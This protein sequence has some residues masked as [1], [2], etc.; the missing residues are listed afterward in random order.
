MDWIVFLAVSMKTWFLLSSS[1]FF[2]DQ[3]DNQKSQPQKRGVKSY[4]NFNQC[5]ESPKTRNLK[6]NLDRSMAVD[7]RIL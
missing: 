6:Q 4:E 7:G 5:G 2:K 3:G 1:Y